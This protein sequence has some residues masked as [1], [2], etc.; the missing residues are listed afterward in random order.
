MGKFS[1]LMSW[2][3]FCHQENEY[4]GSRQ[5]REEY[6]CIFRGPI[7]LIVRSFIQWWNHIFD[8]PDAYVALF[9][10]ILA[11]GTLA[12]WW[13]TRRLWAVTKVAAEHIPRVERAYIIG[14]GP[15]RRYLQDGSLRD[16]PAIGWVSIGNYGKTSAI[17]K[18]IEW[19]FCDPTVFPNDLRVSEILDKHEKLIPHIPIIVKER[20]D[21]LR[22][23]QGP[24]EVAGGAFNTLAANGRI[25]FGRFTYLILF[26]DVVHFSTFKLQME[27]GGSFGLPGSYS[28]W[29]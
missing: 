23:G 10:G 25:F 8:K 3:A 27:N 17:L 9:T 21:V 15:L 12:L 7:T 28:D 16:H 6:E 2:A 19:G 18:K 11:V 22:P 1:A 4:G 20:E 24:H 13:S 29:K 14:G 5:P 26:D